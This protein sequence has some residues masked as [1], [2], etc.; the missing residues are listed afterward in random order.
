MKLPGS[1]RTHI[2]KWLPAVLMMIVIFWFSAQPGAELPL[3]AWADLVSR[4]QTSDIVI[5][6]ACRTVQGII[7]DDSTDPSG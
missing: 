4:P 3:F 7:E 1:L 5:A 2:A 6:D